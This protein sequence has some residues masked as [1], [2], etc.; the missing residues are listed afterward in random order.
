MPRKKDE[1]MKPKSTILLLSCMLLLPLQTVAKDTGSQTYV[2]R[3]GDTLW[4][5]SE[6]FIKDPDYWPS[7]WSHNP[8]LPNPHF[9]Y[10]GQTLTIYDSGFEIVPASDVPQPMTPPADAP[11]LAKLPM[12][13]ERPL[14]TFRTRRGT[15]GFIAR[16]ELVSTG[17]VV[18][19]VDNR[20]MIAAG[21]T[22]FLEMNNLA[23]VT[24]GDQ[25][26]A[27]KVGAPVT[28]P[29][30]G[31]VVGHKVSQLGTIR[32]AS[33]SGNV[34]TGAV[35]A[36]FREM[37]RG[38]RLRPFYPSLNEISLRRASR[39]MTGLLVAAEDEK[40]ALGTQDIIYLDLGASDGLEVG[41]VLTIS[42]S[43][44]VSEMARDRQ[45]LQ[46]PEMLLGAAIVLETYPRSATALVIKT[47]GPLYRG[48]RVSTMTD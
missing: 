27:F 36:S 16:D 13:E 30:D 23:A 1:P 6:R 9:I 24:V 18:D 39:P 19:T 48:D 5:I 21:D 8:E 44:Q 38:A 34:A 46:L 31:T 47:A 41:N 25:L 12:G 35:T 10:P 11:E 43:R 7:L 14:V 4:G 17:T 2:V 45:D 26:S 28:H 29:T 40:I 37:E 20:I 22:V 33:I 42:R 32:V 15:E 3:P